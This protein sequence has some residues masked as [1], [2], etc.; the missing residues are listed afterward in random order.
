MSMQGI[1][2]RAMKSAKNVVIG[3]EISEGFINTEQGQLAGDRSNVHIAVP[4]LEVTFQVANGERRQPFVFTLGMILPM[5]HALSE[6]G[7]RHGQASVETAPDEVGG[8]RV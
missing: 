8:P 5:I 6:W 4:A 2:L 3:F 1:D 7:V